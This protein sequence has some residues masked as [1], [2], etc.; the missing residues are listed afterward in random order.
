MITAF[1][2]SALM[3]FTAASVL[4]VVCAAIVSGGEGKQ[5]YKKTLDKE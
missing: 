5:K 3:L 2:I 4:I 1:L